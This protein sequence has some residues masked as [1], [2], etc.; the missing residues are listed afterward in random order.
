MSARNSRAAKA[1]RRK[2]RARRDGERPA[3]REFDPDGLV[4]IQTWD[5]VTSAAGRGET[6]PCGCDAHQLL[7]SGGWRSLDELDD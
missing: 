7:H 1:A 3:V 2:V 6:L 4:Q 5:E